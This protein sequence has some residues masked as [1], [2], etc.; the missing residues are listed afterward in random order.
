MAT[1]TE[2]DKSTNFI[3]HIQFLVLLDPGSSIRNPRSGM[4]KIIILDPGKISQIRN[5]VYIGRT[6]VPTVFILFQLLRD[7]L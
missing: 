3:F 7:L 6:F 5:T 4:E 2:K 1:K